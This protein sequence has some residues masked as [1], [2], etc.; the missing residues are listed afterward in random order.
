MDAG[1]EFRIELKDGAALAVLAIQFVRNKVRSEQTGSDH[2][3]IERQAFV[4]RSLKH[5]KE[6]QTLRETYGPAFFLIGAYSSKETRTENL[7]RKIAGS[8]VTEPLP[9]HRRDAQEL[10]ARDENES[11]VEFGQA[12][13]DSFPQADVF[14]DISRP[15]KEVRAALD[16]FIELVFGYPFHTPT[17][18]EYG[19]FH[20]YASALR[21]SAMGRQVG[22]ALCNAEGDVIALGTNEVPK[23]FGG[24]YWGD[25]NEDRRDFQVG[26]DSNDEIKRQNIAEIIA[27]LKSSQWLVPDIAGRESNSLVGEAVGILRGTRVLSPIEYGRAVHAE[28]SAIMDAARRGVSVRGAT[29]YTSTFPCHECARHIITAG[30]ERVY[31]IEPYPKSLALDLHKDAVSVEIADGAK[32]AFLPF[33][34]VAPRQYMNVFGMKKRKDESTGEIVSWIARTALPVQSGP[35]KSYFEA[36]DW[37]GAELQRKM[38]SSDL[39]P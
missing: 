8:E 18:A 19:M 31:Y 28:M 13:R 6:I 38:A 25:E 7:A 37:I 3:P 21:S 12:V 34:G 23:A 35:F 15:R 17:R 33:V 24:Q 32:V 9:E 20:A 10:I 39:L 36:E 27:R 30:I 22:A 4:F 14:V 16:R 2:T 1:N 26:V 5:P 29:L 11:G